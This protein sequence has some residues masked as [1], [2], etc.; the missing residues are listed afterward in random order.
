MKLIV[1]LGNIGTKYENTRHN[2]G[3][4]VADVLA[5]RWDLSNWKEGDNALYL[6]RRTSEKIFLIKPTTY[7]NLSGFAVRDFVNFYHIAL[8]D[9]AIIQ[10]DLD[11]PCGQIRIRRKGSAG[12]HN[13]IKSIQE[14]LASGE[15]TR[16]KVG[17][18]HP[19]GNHENVIKHVLQ[20][21]YA[22]EKDLIEEALTK[23]ADA[24]E[25][26][27]EQGI[28]AVMQEYNKKNR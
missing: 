25:C 17:I 26:W 2:I 15:F 18:G 24:V 4:M 7:M 12:G 27:L 21:F 28:E 23:T 16:F 1:G 13:G 19:T 3:F 20:G 6:E 9:I 8:E 22:D 14:Q 11:L 5:K 10:D